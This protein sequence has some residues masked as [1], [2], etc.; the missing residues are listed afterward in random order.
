MDF[1]M[2]KKLEGILTKKTNTSRLENTSFKAI[3]H[4]GICFNT[5]IIKLDRW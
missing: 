4:T 2:Q 5:A 3:L 1:M